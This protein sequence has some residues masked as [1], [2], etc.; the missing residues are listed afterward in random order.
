MEGNWK[1]TPSNYEG[2]AQEWQKAQPSRGCHKNHL[3]RESALALVKISLTWSGVDTTTGP[4]LTEWYLPVDEGRMRMASSC[5]LRLIVVSMT[6]IIDCA[7]LVDAS[8]MNVNVRSPGYSFTAAST[9]CAGREA[10]VSVALVKLAQGSGVRSAHKVL[11]RCWPSAG[12]VLA[13]MACW[14]DAS[15]LVAGLMPGLVATFG[16]Q[17]IL[18]RKHIGCAPVQSGRRK[19][20][21]C[22]CDAGVRI[23]RAPA[24]SALTPSGAFQWQAKSSVQE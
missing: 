23:S 6:E 16:A 7:K 9:S 21:H 1:A 22:G 11:A 2:Q 24:Q 5:T 17:R 15:G 20:A 13:L 19:S 8:P 3:H 12:S 18:S 4:I 14:S 10:T